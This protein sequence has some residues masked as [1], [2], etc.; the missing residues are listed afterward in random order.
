M[1]AETPIILVAVPNPYATASAG[2]ARIE[3]ITFPYQGTLQ[4]TNHTSQSFA[5]H[6]A[7]NA[8]YFGQGTWITS[9]SSGMIDVGQTITINYTRL[10]LPMGPALV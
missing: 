2:F 4:L 5:W 7:M 1:P 6:I 9:M 10:P 8:C 3:H